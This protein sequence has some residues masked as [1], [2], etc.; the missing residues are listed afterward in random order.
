MGNPGLH[1]GACY[2]LSNALTRRTLLCWAV[3]AVYLGIFVMLA[4]VVDAWVRLLVWLMI[5]GILRS[6][7]DAGTIAVVSVVASEI[8]YLSGMLNLPGRDV[9]LDDVLLN[10]L[11]RAGMGFV[12]G[13]L[14]FAAV[15]LPIHLV[16]WA[17]QVHRK[18]DG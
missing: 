9:T 12:I 10:L 13:M 17:R 16:N 14:C 11:V 2:V 15:E 18:E 3:A 7:T 4:P 8:V 6:V 1:K 5:L